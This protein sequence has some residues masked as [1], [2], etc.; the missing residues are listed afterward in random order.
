MTEGIELPHMPFN[1]SPISTRLIPE[2]CI[3]SRSHEIDDRVP[4]S[5]LLG[6]VRQDAMQSRLEATTRQVTQRVADIDDGV[7]RDRSDGSPLLRGWLEDL[8]TFLIAEQ[9][10]QRSDVCVGYMACLVSPAF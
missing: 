2:V 9:E 3:F 4:I 7:P 1:A 10:S 6:G 5:R 8:E